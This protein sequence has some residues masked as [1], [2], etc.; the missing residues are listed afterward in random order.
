MPDYILEPLD[1]DPELIFADFVDYVQSSFPDWNPSNGQ[2][3]VI[4]A[5]FFAI[6]CAFTADMS[7]RVQRAIYRY[8]GASLANIPPLP[9][10]PASMTASFVV[11]GDNLLIAHV[12][13]GGT[14]VGVQDDF[15]DMQMFA[16]LND[17]N[18]AI[19]QANP[20]AACQAIDLGEAGN[21]LS[22]TVQM[23]ELV[24]WIDSATVVGQSSGGTDPESDDLYI[25]RLTANLTIP[26]RPALGPDFALVST[27][28][29][30]VWRTAVIDNY[31]PGPPIDTA[32]E[33]MIAIS[34]VDEAGIQIS[35][36]IR[37][38]LLDY[39][40]SLVRQNFVVNWMPV[41]NDSVQITVVATAVKGVEIDTTE[42]AVENALKAYLD[43]STYGSG[44]SS[45]QSRDWAVTPK[46][47]YLELTT[48]VENTIGVDF[49]ESL[50]FALNGGTQN[51]TDK[52]F[53]GVFT[54]PFPI[55]VNAT[56]H[57]AA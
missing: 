29:P 52:N 43:R 51:V 30:G 12:L 15:G 42:T 14:I 16:L 41:V 39:L 9:G 34:S 28:V 4:I 40:Q 53:T 57:T 1:S 13:P 46:L 33:D 32:A 55:T 26:R 5:R 45:T 37:D 50:V 35:D 8:F 2:L 19:G 23:I 31:D 6:Q 27:N 22:G 25:Q 38:N 56:I 17:M 21:N 24:D 7:S 49:V 36:A 18:V 3:D 47:R 20:T 11:S 54:L 44:P 48:I 10:S